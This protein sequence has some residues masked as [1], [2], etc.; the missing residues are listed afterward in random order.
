MSR[1]EGR[2]YSGGP[3][4]LIRRTAVAGELGRRGKIV[5]KAA[6]QRTRHGPERDAGEERAKVV[7]ARGVR[8]LVREHGL[9]LERGER[10][11]ERARYDDTRPHETRAV[12]E[13]FAA[14]RDL[15][16][17]RVVRTTLRL[18]ALRIEQGESA[19][20]GETAAE[21]VRRGAAD[22]DEHRGRDQH[23]QRGK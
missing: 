8:A 11:E 9:A 5:Q 22:R 12:C 2:G 16:R 18:A 10:V 20:D 17:H 7:A 23:E 15:D 14:L 3:A 6:F 13:P 1:R 21:P 19:G 4:N